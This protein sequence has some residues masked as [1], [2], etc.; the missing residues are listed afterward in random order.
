[1]LYQILWHIMFYLVSYKHTDVITSLYDCVLFS[2][3]QIDTIINGFCRYSFKI[4]FKLLSDVTLL[5]DI[6]S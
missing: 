1:M 2:K 5:A 3:C 4:Y 6:M